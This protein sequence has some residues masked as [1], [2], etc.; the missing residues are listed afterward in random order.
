MI[1]IFHST[2]P[3]SNQFPLSL[4]VTWKQLHSARHA[5]LREAHA[6]GGWGFSVVS[7][8]IVDCKAT[9]SHRNHRGRGRPFKAWI[10]DHSWQWGKK[11]GATQ[12]VGSISA[13]DDCVEQ[14][15]IVLLTVALPHLQSIYCIYLYIL[16]KLEFA[17]VIN[18]LHSLLHKTNRINHSPIYINIYIYIYV[19]NNN[20]SKNKM[21]MCMY[22][23][24]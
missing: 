6:V 15:A 1:S 22:I 19:I 14:S 21:I 18:K 4:K 9:G 20:N 16:C 3:R 2:N 24:I 7:S 8:A 5:R 12:W 17:H 11:C 10:F 23:Y 13:V